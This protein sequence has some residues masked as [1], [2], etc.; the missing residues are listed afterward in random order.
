LRVGC[1]VRHKARDDSWM[2]CHPKPEERERARR[3][4]DATAVTD[5]QA[6]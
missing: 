3:Y 2:E 4:F 5:Q 1:V 6:P